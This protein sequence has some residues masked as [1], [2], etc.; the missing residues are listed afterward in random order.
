MTTTLHA[1]RCGGHQLADG[2]RI[3][4][5]KTPAPVIPLLSAWAGPTKGIDTLFEAAVRFAAAEPNVSDQ[6]AV[7]EFASEQYHSRV[8]SVKLARL[9]T[10]ELH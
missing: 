1:K 3:A 7:G 10:G 6:I 2:Q 5:R 9:G 8:S 4:T